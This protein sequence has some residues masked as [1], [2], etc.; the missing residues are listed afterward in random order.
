VAT[1]CLSAIDSPPGMLSRAQGLVAVL[2]FPLVSAPLFRFLCPVPP[3]ALTDGGPSSGRKLRRGVAAGNARVGEGAMGAGAGTVLQ[4]TSDVRTG[5]TQ[6]RIATDSTTPHLIDLFSP[7]LSQ[8]NQQTVGLL[9]VCRIA[10]FDVMFFLAVGPTMSDKTRTLGNRLGR[11]EP[12]ACW[13]VVLCRLAGGLLPRGP[14]PADGVLARHVVLSWAVP[15]H[16][17][18]RT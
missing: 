6:C 9:L 5:R 10:C 11:P 16:I 7:S 18:L 17:R 12:A 8:E 4:G 15:D 14:V 1:A 13:R 3:V 2:L